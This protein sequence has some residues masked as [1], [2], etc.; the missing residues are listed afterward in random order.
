MIEKSK[1]IALSLAH[2]RCLL[3]L[4]SLVIINLSSF[5]QVVKMT[6]L[7]LEQ[8]LPSNESYQVLQDAKGFIWICTD[9]GVAQ[10]NGQV[11]ETF[12]TADGLPE[13]TIFRMYE[14]YTNRLWFIGM[15]GSL[16]YWNGKS[17]QQPAAHQ[18]IA[19]ILKQ[20]FSPSNIAVDSNDIIY[21]TESR[22]GDGY[23]SVGIADTSVYFHALGKEYPFNTGRLILNQT[24]DFRL[25]NIHQVSLS[26]QWK[27]KRKAVQHPVVAVPQFGKH[28]RR[29]YGLHS[30]KQVF[31]SK[32]MAW[33]YDTQQ[34][35]LVDTIPKNPFLL[36]AYLDRQEQL[37]VSTQKGLLFYGKAPFLTSPKRFLTQH[38]IATIYQDKEGSYWVAT[39]NQGVFFI[40]NWDVLHFF[41]TP[42]SKIQRITAF[43]DQI[44]G[45]G[46]DQI[47]QVKQQYPFETYQNSSPNQTIFFDVT[48]KKD[49]LLLPDGSTG[50]LNTDGTLELGAKYYQYKQYN[51]KS[52]FV[53]EPKNR[54][55]M[56]YVNGLREVHPDTVY[57]HC[58]GHWIQAIVPQNTHAWWLGTPKGLLYYDAALDSLVDLGAQQALL[59]QSILDLIPFQQNLL[60]AT[61]GNGVL[62]VDPSTGQVVQQWTSADGLASPF[63]HCFESENDSVLWVGTNQ[64]INRLT[65]K[66]SSIQTAL[67]LNSENYLASNGVN[68]IL[69]NDSII[70]VATD[71]GLAYLPKI[72]FEQPQTSTAIPMAFTNIQINGSTVPLQSSYHLAHHQ[73]NIVLDFLALSYKTTAALSYRYQLLHKESSPSTWNYTKVPK[74][75]FTQLEAGQYTLRIQVSNTKGNWQAKGLELSFHIRPH[76]TQ[77]WW[78]ILGA[79]GLVVVVIASYW[80]SVLNKKNLEKELAEAEQKALR[81]QMN[82]HFLF[83]AINSVFYFLYKNQKQGALDFLQK[84]AALMRSTLEHT[85]HALISLEKDL[86]HTQLYLDMEAARL[87]SGSPHQHHFQIITDKT[88]PLGNW[89][90]PPMLIQPLV[91]NAILHGLAPKEADCQLTVRITSVPTG[92]NIYVEDNGIGR[93]AAK[94]LQKQ[95][96]IKK[97]SQGL[98]LLQQRIKTINQLLQT[99][100]SLQLEDFPAASN[101]STRCT[102][103][104][105][106]H[107]N[108]KTNA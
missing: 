20:R 45:V 11:L 6:Q 13:N 40:N 61:K 95:F 23:Y 4:F 83:N 39:L 87:S 8:G 103:H 44:V 36:S 48:T 73:Q 71:K 105:P 75:N 66:D 67:V 30:S 76:F 91:E 86:E 41:N 46:L 50:R 106:H 93:V 100:I 56:G 3:L 1:H 98:Q 104:L 7:N 51:A 2:Q 25:T 80:R 21:F 78:F 54:I 85:Q 63:I 94:A 79:T 10:Y 35:T 16:S 26:E 92:L 64:G 19:Q 5:A 88:I 69:I 37:W 53:D 52:I 28:P 17:I 59:S 74:L 102:I 47:Y 18:E 32:S 89:M 55:L 34:D 31:F 38:S 57:Y 62:V 65:I 97:T 99:N 14:D 58:A 22:G 42:S 108:T 101:C 82:P 27:G 84:F 24:T 77:T 60:V 33:V 70:W 43:Q 9:H 96:F 90:I 107:L 29:D 49:Q 15:E 12:S 81:S 72:L 68:D